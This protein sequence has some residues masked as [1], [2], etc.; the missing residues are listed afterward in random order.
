M[1]LELNVELKDTNPKIWRKIQV[2]ADITLDNLHD[3][4][5][6]SMGWT[7]SHLY[8]FIIAEIEYSSKDYDY[9]NY[10]YGNSRSYQLKEFQ[11]EHIEYLYDFGDYWEHSIQVLKKIE[12]EKLLNPICLD[13]KGKCPPEDVGGIPGF[14]EFLK[15]M[16]DKSNP[17]RESYIE[18]YGSEFKPDEFSLEEINKNLAKVPL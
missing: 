18:W 1:I 13:G 4:I 8:S 7:N 9:D 6:T 17:E 11:N 14:G 2:N 10:K 5:Q 16:K 15:I 3:I 12:G